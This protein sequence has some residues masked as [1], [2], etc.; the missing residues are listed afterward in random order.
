MEDTRVK[1][2]DPPRPSPGTRRLYLQVD[3]VAM[4]FAAPK[5]NL[6]HLSSYRPDATH[7]NRHK[8]A[9]THFS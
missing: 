2:H 1:D 9:Q 6:G 7:F 4:T 3:T 8:S 5:T